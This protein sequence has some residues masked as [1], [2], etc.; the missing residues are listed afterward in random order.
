MIARVIRFARR[1]LLCAT[2]LVSA[3]KLRA[4]D[5]AAPGAWA[6]IVQGSGGEAEYTQA[7]SDWSL[8][9]EREL[10]EGARL[11][12]DRI[13]RLGEGGRPGAAAP[14]LD[15]IG[16][17][18]GEL[19]TRVGPDDDLL[20]FLIGHGSSI[21]GEA[22]FIIPGKD[23]TPQAL[24]EMLAPVPAR[25]LVIVDSTASSAGFIPVLS[26]P[27]R[28]VATATKGEEERNATQ[29]MEFFLTGLEDGSADQN[30][31]GRISLLEAC[32]QA[33][34][35]TPAWYEA[36]GYLVT[37][38]PLLDDNGDGLGTRLV[39]SAENDL[40]AVEFAPSEG[41]P[42][43]GAAAA[44]YFLRDYSFP[45]TVPEALSSRYLGLLEEIEDMK[46]R[47]GSLDPEEYR[48]QLEELLIQAART[49]RDIRR[50]AAEGSPAQSGDA[51]GEAAKPVVKAEDSTD[52]PG[53]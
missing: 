4:E 22:R 28:I 45:A 7:F 29:F 14:S 30:R 3:A 5:S 21:N 35:L 40:V 32:R 17:A 34:A 47:K 20:V 24:L 2:L 48:E 18:L 26:G 53:Q 49:H 43:D 33:A 6:F 16:K 41:S 9:L 11:A 44:R 25:R 19:S 39:A 27:G 51:D 8:R 36:E 13:V 23:L 52:V 1:L 15:E 50:A 46:E 12:P 38:H 10:R 37:E 31:D 42:L